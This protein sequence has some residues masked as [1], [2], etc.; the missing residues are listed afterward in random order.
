MMVEALVKLSRLARTAV[1]SPRWPCS[2][3]WSARSIVRC[4]A[5]VATGGGLAGQW[6][7]GRFSSASRQF[8]QSLRDGGLEWRKLTRRR[9]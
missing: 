6:L 7:K 9:N 4:D 5:V 3:R 8:P 2:L 1:S